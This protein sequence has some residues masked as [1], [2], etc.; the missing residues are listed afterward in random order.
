MALISKIKG[1]NNIDYN[2]RDDVSVWGGRNLLSV[3]KY[4]NVSGGPDLITYDGWITDSTSTSDGRSWG[5]ANCN[6]KLSLQADTYILTWYVK[7]ATTNTNNGIG[8]YSSSG[9]SLWVSIGSS[10]P[11]GTVGTN[12]KI[13]TLTTD[14]D[15]GIMFKI[16]DGSVRLKLER[17]TKSTD[18]SPAPEDIA[19]VN[20]ECLE[21]LG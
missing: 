5:Y 11:F 16:Y 1:T 4:I 12:S 9:S 7:T 8:I 14:T 2:V 3:N 15:I 17:G 6:W 10:D 13:I 19:Y 18:W 21:L 20:G